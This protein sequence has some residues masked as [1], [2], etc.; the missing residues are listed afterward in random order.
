M[1]RKKQKRQRKVGQKIFFLILLIVAITI[2]WLVYN[3]Y[4]KDKQKVDKIDE[5][6]EESSPKVEEQ[7][8]EEKKEEAPKKDESEIKKENGVTIIDEDD[9]NNSDSVT[10]YISSSGVKGDY[11]KIIVTTEQALSEG[12]CKLSLTGNREYNSVTDVVAHPG[13]SS[14]VFKMNKD[15]IE[16]G[17]YHAEITVTTTGG[18]SGTITGEV[19]K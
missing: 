5:K 6:K 7:Q 19:E 12:E 17:K 14:C 2:G 1:Q 9:P 8:K 16:D 3:A 4:F 11:F 10:G 15:E 13:S 18:R